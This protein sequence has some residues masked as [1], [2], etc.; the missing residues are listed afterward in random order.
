MLTY[1]MIFISE[2]NWWFVYIP[3]HIHI[4]KWIYKETNTFTYK[5]TNTFI[6]EEINTFTSKE[7]NILTHEKYINKTFILYLY[8]E[9]NLQISASCTDIYMH[10]ST[11]SIDSW[12]YLF[13]MSI[14]FVH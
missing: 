11:F 13:I 4:I 7:I 6:Y 1:F 14:Q 3:T 9:V 12:I 5:E 2:Q 8:R 10:A